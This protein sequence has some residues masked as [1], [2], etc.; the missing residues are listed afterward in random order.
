M[1]EN[2]VAR[3]ESR[4]DTMVEELADLA[5]ADPEALSPYHLRLLDADVFWRLWVLYRGADEEFQRAVVA[6]IESGTSESPAMLAYVLTQTRGRVA[7]EAFRRWMQSPPTEPDF[8]PYQRGV[9]ALIRDGGWELAEDGVRELCGTS[10][11]R[12][13]PEQGGDRT[14]DTCPWCTSPLWTVLDVDTSDPRVR[15]ALAHTRWRGRLRIV[16]CQ[17]CSCYGTT[18]AEVAADGGAR[19]SAHNER[20]EYLP[21]GGP[22]E[23]PPVRLTLGEQWSTPYLASAWNR[24]GST[25][26]GCPDWIQ[27]PVYLDCPNCGKAMD[28]VGLVGGADLFEYGEGAYYLFL[29]TQCGLAAVEYQQS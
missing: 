4:D 7:Q 6:R 16:T 21:G 24:E 28:Y 23:P 19:W 5:A 25:L 11:Y 8:D 17:I 27:D 14:A 22:E 10:A 29:H 9:A 15:D 1:I 12:L 13:V 2:L 3:V 20:P 26:G 18:Y